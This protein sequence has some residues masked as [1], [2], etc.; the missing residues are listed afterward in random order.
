MLSYVTIIMFI[1][2]VDRI[3]I[4]AATGPIMEEFG[5]S[6][7]QWGLILSAFFWGLVP[8]AF[9]SGIA[10]DKWGPKKV[11]NI[12]VTWWSI[13]TIATPFAFNYVTFLIARIFFGAGEGPTL[14]NGIRVISNWVSPR[15]TS[16]AACVVF[17]G[18]KLGPALGT[19]IIVWIIATYG[20]RV[21]FYVMGVMGLVWLFG[22]LRIFTDS[23]ADNKYMSKEEKAWLAKEQG[24]VVSAT[25]SDKPS[26]K[27]LFSMPKEVRKTLVTNLFSG[28]CFGYVLYFSMTWLPG[29]LTMELNMSLKTMGTVIMVLWLFA[30]FTSVIGARILDKLINKTGNRRIWGYWQSASF[31][32]I[33]ICMFFA[34]FVDS[35]SLIL[36][37]LTIAI[38]ANTLAESCI[39]SVIPSIAPER[40]GSQAGLLQLAYTVPG[41]IAPIVTG[42]IVDMTN[43][44]S[45]AFFLIAILVTIGS[46]V[47]LLFM[48]P[49]KMDVKGTEQIK[50][51]I[52][53]H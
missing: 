13:F 34:G 11:W 25:I 7:T 31:L 43:S 9:L 5:F 39:N 32:I 2:F 38:S 53:N 52:I 15:E 3:I 46:I 12:G 10:A 21:A 45:F 24:N 4:S 1:N 8:F 29:Y 16:T 28:F 17:L 36:V 41:I 6:A 49:S 22:W 35:V 37:F 30:A 50:P 48:R 47:S 44:F 20:W 14:S 19:P 26:F 33:G 51:I 40:A 42:I 18:V 27:E 23:P